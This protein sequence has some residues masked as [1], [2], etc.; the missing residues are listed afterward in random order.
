M[1]NRLLCCASLTLV[2]CVVIFAQTTPTPRVAP[3]EMIIDQLK[4]TVVFLQT[5]WHDS[6][7]PSV[8]AGPSDQTGG[9]VGTGFLIFEAI[10]EW[11]KDAAGDDRGVDF[12]VTAKHMIRREM[13]DKQPGPYADKVTVRFNT[14]APVD[15]SGRSWDTF[16]APILDERGDLE[17]LVD[18]AD[19]VADVALDFVSMPSGADCKTIGE[20]SFAT[21][22]FVTDQHI[23]ENDEV[24]FA[25]LFTGYFGALRNY[26]IVR[27]GKLALLPGEDVAVDP[28]KPDHKSQIYLAEISSF[29]G[30]SGSPVFVR[31]GTLRE[32]LTVNMNVGYSYRLLGI[33]KGFVSDT[34]AKQNSGIALVVP[35]DKI[36]EILSG[37]RAKAF[38]ARAV[39]DDE[40]RK[41]DLNDA[42]M[43]FRESVGLL[44]K[45]SPNSSQLLVT[46]REFAAMLQQA[47][48]ENEARDVLARAQRI[49]DQPLFPK[50]EP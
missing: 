48:R 36:Q 44:E 43:K 38:I 35:V 2:L 23:N 9:I 18:D 20:D 40:V 24:L 34:E 33:M 25:G 29:G 12:L 19:P 50:P 26:P 37:D 3:T 45:H 11:G 21:K 32:G 16:D 31:L 27:H 4:K 5:T 17:W 42:E 6:T 14:L 10:P 30:N 47:N 13:P 41:G 28:A 15:A 22:S 7:Q 8:P 49:A 1:L 46:L 39:A